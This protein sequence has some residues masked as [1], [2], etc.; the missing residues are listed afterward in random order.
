MKLKYLCIWILFSIIISCSDDGNPIISNEFDYTSK[1]PEDPNAPVISSK[2]ENWIKQN[3][4]QIK[5]I[6]SNDFSDLQFYKTL[7]VNKKIVQLGESSHGVKEFNQAKVRM[8][9]FLHEEMGFNII[10]FE[11]SVYDCFYAFNNKL[12]SGANS[13]MGNSIYGVWYTNEVKELFEYLIETQNTDNPLRLVGFDTQT[14]AYGRHSRPHFFKEVFSKIDTSEAEEIYNLD[15][16]FQSLNVF[17]DSA[18]EAFKPMAHELRNHYQ[19]FINVLENNWDEMS[20]VYHDNLQIPHIAKLSLR[21]NIKVIDAIYHR[22]LNEV[23][24]STAVR[25]SNMAYNLDYLIKK[26]Y[27]EDKF[28]VWAHNYHIRYNNADV[29]NTYNTGTESMGHHLYKLYS[30]KIYSIGFYMY[31]GKVAGNDKS[32]LDVTLSSNDNIEAILY[33]ARNYFSFVDMRGQIKEEGNSWM[34]MEMKVKYWGLTDQ[35]MIP[36]DQYDGIFFVYKTSIPDYFDPG[37]LSKDMRLI[38]LEE[39]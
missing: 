9:K 6:Q 14:S 37:R 16:Y 24:K 13:L 2:W 19:H 21:S 29:K 25:D 3:S 31:T 12:Q 32:E 17:S 5:S 8:I 28:I 10:A 38:P 26:V 7:L 27:T 22:S 36:R 20:N 34:F 15:I 18:R 39:R 33:R 23:V 4:I 1:T 30:D 11:S 35:L